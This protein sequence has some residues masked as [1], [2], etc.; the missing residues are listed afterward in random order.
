MSK[1]PGRIA[2]VAALALV[3]VTGSAIGADKLPAGVIA[4]MGDVE[5]KTDELKALVDALPPDARAQVAANP[6]ALDRVVRNEMIRRALAAE[7]RAKGWDKRPE[8]V[9]Q[10]DRAR[11]V[12]LV[13]AYMNSVARPPETFPSDAE[14]KAAYEQN[15]ASLTTPKQYRISQIFVL[16]PPETDKAG[17]AKALAKATDLAE[18]AKK[19]G[20]D[21]AALA[22]ASSEHADSAGKG[23]DMGYVA[24]GNLIPE[25]RD[26]I[27]A[28]KK[29]DIVGPIKTQAGWHVIRLEDV[30]EKG[31][32]PLAE[33][34]DQIANSLRLRRAQETEQAYLT[35]MTN[36]TPVTIN[37]AELPRLQPAAAPK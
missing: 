29:G 32:R 30:R 3:V 27:A 4:R 35:V 10:M 11:E 7:A 24:D 6:A 2:A 8:V 36:R 21:F 16:A 15:A 18:R 23:G 25:L 12:A 5:L 31:V 17:V 13:A 28:M 9:A 33:V 34:R 20:A 1:L 37:E 22:K 26:P 14:I 19:K